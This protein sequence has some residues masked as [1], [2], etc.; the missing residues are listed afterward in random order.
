M[1][2]AAV[3]LI[4]GAISEF[5][6]LVLIAWP[7]LVPWKRQASTWLR[8]TYGT[9]EGIVRRILRRPRQVTVARSI[10]LASSIEIAGSLRRRR[11]CSPDASLEEKVHF[12]LSRDTDAQRFEADVLE[13]LRA[14]EETTESR[15]LEASKDLQR[16][17]ETR[18]SETAQEFR[19][20]RVVGLVLLI[21]GLVA[22]TAVNF[23]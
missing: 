16:R 12:L 19:P 22:T 18:L 14:I 17:L 8:Q 13:R 11:G 7:D 20:L 21:I 6:G 4:L 10:G 9:A 2:G 1:S 23:V 15:L 3:T 5:A